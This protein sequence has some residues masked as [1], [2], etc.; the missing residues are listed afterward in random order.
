[1]SP[2]MMRAKK[3]I[4]IWRWQAGRYRGRAGF[5]EFE[6][7]PGFIGRFVMLAFQDL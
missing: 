3:A 5:R 6:Y 4:V 1:M 2:R 7:L